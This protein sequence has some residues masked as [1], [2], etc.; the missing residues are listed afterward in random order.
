M[1]YYKGT[2]VLEKY[3]LTAVQYCST[4]GVL[5]YST[6]VLQANYSTVLQ[7]YRLTKVQYCS[8]TCDYNAVLQYYMR[9]QY[10]TQYY[11][12]TTV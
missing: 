5:Q 12:V 9:L 1:Q 4:T 7:Y 8:T 6:A 3:S 2:T 11:R 10:N